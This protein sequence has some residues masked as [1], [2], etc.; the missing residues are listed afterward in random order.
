MEFQQ[1]IPLEPSQRHKGVSTFVHQ[2]EF[3]LG[4]HSVQMERQR[5]SIKCID[6]QFIP[7]PLF[8][9]LIQ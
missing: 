7:Y 3:D 9:L 6:L 8:P 5:H 4:I 1:F 2:L